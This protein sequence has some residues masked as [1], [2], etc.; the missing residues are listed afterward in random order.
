[1]QNI[2]FLVM[3]VD[4]TLTDGKIYMGE[5]GEMMKAFDIKDGCGIKTILPEHHII[6]IIITGRTSKIVENR[7]QELGIFELHQDVKNKE[8]R[9]K[10]ILLKYAKQD[11]EDYSYKNVAYIG[12]DLL[13]FYCM[14]SLKAYGGRIGCPSDAI[15]EIIDISDFISNRSGGSGAVREFIEWIVNCEVL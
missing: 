12:D 7:C 15:K 4:G 11:A 5:N 9:L 14:K 1:M 10:K 13:D 6:P 8:E 3:D 2:K